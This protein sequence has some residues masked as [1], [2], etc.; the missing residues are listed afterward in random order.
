[1]PLYN[2]HYC[3]ISQY[4]LLPPTKEI[5]YPL[6]V[7]PSSHPLATTNAMP[8]WIFILSTF[9]INGIIQYA[10]FYVWLLSLSIMWKGPSMIYYVSVVLFLVKK[11]FIVWIP[12]I[13]FIHYQLMAIRV[14]STFLY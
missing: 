2:H 3:L 7:S 11:Y 14:V 4:F 1:M 5:I 8:L 9:H 6:P 10:V 12:Y 13:W